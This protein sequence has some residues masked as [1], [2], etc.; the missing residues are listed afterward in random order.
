MAVNRDKP[1][2]WKADIAA[3]VDQFNE[4]FIR[5]APTAFRDQREKVAADVE[6]SFLATDALR[7]I[8][9]SILKLRPG[10]LPALRMATCPPLARDRLVGLAKVN[11][12]LVNKM[13]NG[14]LPLRMAAA[15]LDA[16][17]SQIA[18]VIIKLVDEDVCPWIAASRNPSDAE[19]H[20]ASTVVADRLCGSLANPIIRNAQEARQLKVLAQWLHRRGYRP[21][22]DGEGPTIT[23]FPAGTYAFRRNAEGWVDEDG[24]K[25]VG[26]PVDCVVMPLG[27]LDSDLPVLIEAKSAGDFTNVNKR[28]KEEASK[29]RQ[30]RARWGSSI[31]FVLLLCGYFDTG[32]LGY[33]AAEGIDW[34]WEHRLDDFAQLDL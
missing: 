11:K 5:F 24:S 25:S 23:E 18:E 28:R 19:L 34:V 12:N 6:G 7:D 13:E 14:V 15:R 27:A 16:Q 29:A 30:L 33:E 9:P 10:M 8:T 26:I 4:W 31:P 3:S 22:E 1:D 2:R 32:Y 21:L 17:L 20:R